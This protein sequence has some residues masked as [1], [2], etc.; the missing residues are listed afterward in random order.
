MIMPAWRHVGTFFNNLPTS[1]E[2]FSLE[3][4]SSIMQIGDRFYRM[5]KGTTTVEASQRNDTIPNEANDATSY[6][7]VSSKEFLLTLITPRIILVEDAATDEC[8]CLTLSMYHLNFLRQTNAHE[9]VN[10][11]FC[12]GLEIFTGMANNHSSPG[13][14]LLYPLSMSGSL[15][16]ILPSRDCSTQSLSGWVWAEELQARAAY[17]DLTHSI[18]VFIGVEKQ[19]AMLKD[20]TSQ[21]NTR[22]TQPEKKEE[23]NR[24]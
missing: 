12:D 24:M 11:L 22:I 23:R 8:Q 14:S 19:M 10:T 16:K 20:S 2:E 17:T 13:S 6:Q 4:M 7:T 15:K 18:N 9:E 21:Y 5:S 1:P 3:E